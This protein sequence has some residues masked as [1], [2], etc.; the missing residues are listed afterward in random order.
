VK[1]FEARTNVA[2]RLAVNGRPRR[3]QPDVET[4]LFRIAQEALNN[5][6]KHAE[7]TAVALKLTFNHQAVQLII[8]DDGCG[9]NPDEAMPTAAE[10]RWGL[11]GMKERATLISGNYH[12]KSKPGAGTTIQVDIPLQEKLIHA[13]N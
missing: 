11:L 13:L 8:Q 10:P 9:F 5:V 7:A 6:A 2:A 12:I 1:E 4:E 3:I